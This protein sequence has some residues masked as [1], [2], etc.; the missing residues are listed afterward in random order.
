MTV[1][2]HDW[3]AGEVPANVALGERSWLYSSFAFVHHRSERDPSVRVGPDSGVY[4][5]SYFDL[6]PEGEVE[7][8]RYCAVAGA[9]FPPTAVS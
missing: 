4:V 5:G 6:G 2:G 9:I 3:Y 8:G 7:I 1:L